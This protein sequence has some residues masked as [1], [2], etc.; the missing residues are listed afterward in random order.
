LAASPAAAA[1][2]ITVDAAGAHLVKTQRN[3]LDMW[4]GPKPRRSRF[5]VSHGRLVTVLGAF[6]GIGR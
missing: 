2:A 4:R 3:G 6:D 5:L 1:A